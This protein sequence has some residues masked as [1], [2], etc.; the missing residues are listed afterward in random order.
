MTKEEIIKEVDKKYKEAFPRDFYLW[1]ERGFWLTKLDE[2]LSQQKQEI[3]KEIEKLKIIQGKRGTEEYTRKYVLDL[4][5]DTLQ[6]VIDKIR[7][8]K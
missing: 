6:G 3:I 4:T 1:S 7:K 5:N 2:S 8:L